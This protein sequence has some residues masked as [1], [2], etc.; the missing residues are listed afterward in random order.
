MN[1]EN[2]VGRLKLYFNKEFETSDNHKAT[3]HQDNRHKGRCWFIR[4]K[5]KIKPNARHIQYISD[6]I[7]ELGNK[8]FKQLT[9]RYI[10]S[11]DFNN[12]DKQNGRFEK[13]YKWTQISYD[14]CFV[15]KSDLEEIYE[16]TSPLIKEIDDSIQKII[17]T[18]NKF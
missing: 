12:E 6:N 2:T 8:F 9:K 7:K 15:Y 18:T 1:I 11:I 4:A 17:Q 5:I 16:I 13:K 14:I 10:I 3:I